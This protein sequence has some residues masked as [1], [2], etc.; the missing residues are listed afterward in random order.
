MAAF[1]THNFLPEIFQTDANKKFLNATVDQLISEPNFKRVNGYVGR[2]FAPT[3]KSSDSY[4]SEIDAQRQNYQLEPSVVIIDPQTNGINS[5]SSYTDLINKIKFY[6]GNV[7]NHS[8]MFE[9]EMYSYDGKFDFDKFVNFSQYCWLPNGPDSI[10]ISALG[11][12]LE[13]TWTVRVNSETKTY[14]FDDASKIAGN[15]NIVLARGGVYTFNLDNTTDPFWIQTKQGITGL[16]PSRPNISTRDVVGVTDNGATSGTVVFT[17]PQLSAQSRFTNMTEVAQVDYATSLSYH[18]IQG[19]SI[20]DINS[21]LGGLDGITG[22]LDGKK[23]VFIG[24]SVD[25]YHWTVP[26]NIDTNPDSPTYLT[27]IDPN[28]VVPSENRTKTWIINI[29]GGVVSLVANE[30]VGVNEK[31]YIKSGIANTTK[32][33][34]VDYHSRYVEFPLLTSSL[35]TLYYQNGNVGN[36]NGLITIVDAAALVIDPVNDIIGK[37]SYTSPT[38]VVF[39]N[40]MKIT[41]DSSAIG[42][43]ANNTYYVEGVGKSISLVLESNILPVEQWTKSSVLLAGTGYAVNDLLTVVGGT[44]DAATMIVDT[45]GSSGEILTFFVIDGGNYTTLP[46]NPVTVTGGTGTGAKFD[47]VLQPASKDY[48]TINRNSV[49]LNAW[50]RSNRWFH[51]DVIKATAVYNGTDFAIDQKNIAIR[52]IIEF[53]PNIKLFN[54]GEVARDPIDI[55]DTT[56]TNAYTQIENVS[57]ASSTTFI[58]TVNGTTVILHHG[59]RVVFS[60]DSVLSVRS[61]IYKFSIVNLSEN[62]FPNYVG[63]ITETGETISAGNSV[64]VKKGYYSGNEYYYDGAAWVKGQQKTGINQA[65]LFDMFDNSG[66]SFGDPAAYVNSSFVGTPIFSYKIGTGATDTELGFPLSYRTF[67]NVGDIQFSNSYDDDTFTYLVSPQTLTGKVNTGLLHV[68]KSLGQFDYSNIWSKVIEKSKQYQLISHTADGINNLFEIDILPNPTTTVPNIKVYVNNKFITVDNF[69]LSQIGVRYAVLVNPELLTAGDNVD[70]LIYSNSVSK[71]GFYQVPPSLDNNAENITFTSLTLGQIRNHLITL[72][73]NST[74][75]TGEV[76]GKNNLRDVYIKDHGGSIVKHSSAAVFSQLSLTDDTLNLIDSIGVAQKEYSKF[77]NKFL[78]LATQVHVENGADMSE[79]TDAILKQIN[80]IKNVTFPWYYSDMVPYGDNKTTLPSYTVLDPRIRSYELTTIFDDT[81]LSNKAVLVYLTR[82][83]N[84]TT[85]KKLL[86]KGKDY[87]FSKTNPSF[88]ISD[89]FNLNYGDILTVV[90]YSDTDGNYIPETPTKLGLYA[91]FVPV[92]YTDTT[93]ITPIDVI[94]GHDGSITPAFGDYRDDLLLELELRIYNNIKVTNQFETIYDYIPGKFRV[95]DYNLS[96]FNQ[97]L[98]NNFLTWVGNNRLD[99]TTNSYFDPADPWTYNYKNYK[100][101]INAEQLPGT[102]RAVF[103]WLFDTDRP[104]T[105]PWEMLGFSDEPDWWQDRYG[106]AP[107]TGGNYNLWSDLSIGYIHA[108]DRAGL[109]ARFARPNLLQII[110]VDESGNLRSPYEFAT[111]NFDISKASASFAIGNQGPVETAWRRSSNF[112]Y[113]MQIA[114]ALTKP[115]IY[116]GILAEVS[117]YQY[118]KNVGQYLNKTNNQHLQLSQ[119]VLNGRIDQTTGQITRSAGYTN[120]MSDFLTSTGVGYA[121]EVIAAYLDNLSVKLSYKVSGFTDKNYLKIL[122]EQGSPSSTNDSIVIPDE[123]YKV[124]LNKSTPVDRIVYSAVIVEKSTNGYTVS[125]YALN[126]PYF[127]IVPSIANNRAYSIQSGKLAGT[128]YQDYQKSLV[129]IPYGYEF[130]TSQQVVDFLVSYQRFLQSRGFTFAE[131][132]SDLGTKKDW[133]LSAKEFLTW[134]QQGWQTG[135]ILVLSPVNGTLNVSTVDSVVDSLSG[136]FN[137]TKLLDPNFAAIKPSSYTIVRNDNDFK[138]TTIKGQTICL[139]ELNLVQYEHVLVFDNKTVFNDIIYSPDTGNRQYRLKF[140]GYKTADWTGAMNPPGFVFNNETVDAWQSGKDYRKGQLVTYKNLYYTALSNVIASDTFMQPYWKQISKTQIKTGLLPNFALNAQTFEN[141]YDLDNPDPR[142]NI[143][144]YSSGITGFRERPY[145]T[146]LGID[147]DT[148]AKFYQGYIKQKGT[149]SAIDALAS[150][151]LANINSEIKV[152]EEWALRVGEY[153]ATDS[154]KF[155]EVELNESDITSNPVALQFLQKDETSASGAV[156]YTPTGLYKTSNATNLTFNEYSTSADKITLPVAGYVNVDD[157]DATIFDLS[158]YRNLTGILGSIGT[159]YTIWTAKDFSGQWN[160]FRVSETDNTVVSLTYNIDNVATFTTAKPHNFS[161]GDIVAVRNFD[162]TFDG[163]YQVYSVTGTQ[164]FSVVIANNYTAL[165]DAGTIYN[166]GI[167]FKLVSSRIAN[168]HLVDDITPT[169]GW[170]DNDK[171]WVDAI[172]SNGNWGVYNKTSPWDYQIKVQMNSSEYQ[173]NSG[174]GKSMQLSSDGKFMFVGASGSGRA[175][176]FVKVNKSW[177]ENSS[178]TD[179]VWVQ[180]SSFTTGATNSDQYGDSVDVNA[181]TFSVTAPGSNSN[182]GYVFLY[183]VDVAAG[184]TISQVLTA[185]SPTA[186]GKFGTAIDSSDDGAWLYIS[187]PGGDKVYVYNWKAQSSALQ[188]IPSGSSSVLLTQTVAA[189]SDILVNGN[190]PYIPGVDYHLS[191]NNIVFTTPTT[192]KLVVTYHG[193]Y[194]LYTTLTDPSSLTGIN[195]GY[196]LKTNPSGSQLVIGANNYDSGNGATYIFD[197]SIQRFVSTGTTNIFTPSTSLGTAYKV[198][199]NG[200]EIVDYTKYNNDIV[201][202]SVPAAGSIIDV[203]TNSFSFVQRMV[204]SPSSTTQRMGASVDICKNTCSIYASAPNYATYGYSSGAVYRFV[205]QGRVYGTMISSVKNPTVTLGHSI[206]INGTSVVFRSGTTVDSIVSAINSTNIAGVTATNYNGYVKIDSTSMVQLNKLDILPDTGTAF[207]NIGFIPFVQTQIITHP[208]LGESEYFGSSIKISDD[209]TSLVVSSLGASTTLSTMFDANSTMFDST[210]TEFKDNIAYSGAVYLYDLMENPYES[211]S[212]PSQMVYVQ[213]LMGPGLGSNFKFGSSLEFKNNFVYVG[214]MA[215]NALVDGGGS[216]YEFANSTTTGGWDLIRYET[217]K[218]D[219]LGLTKAFIYNKKTQAI[220]THL[221]VFDPAKGKI[222]GV[223]DQDL[224]YKSETDPAVYN[225]G[226]L[227]YSPTYHW[228]NQQVGRTWWDLSQVRFIDYE[229]DSLIY[230]N[231]HWGATF[232]DSKVIV[233]EWVESSVLPSQYVTNGGNG[234][235]KFADDSNYVSYTY[236]DQST[237]VIKNNYYFWVSGKTTVDTVL[238]NR[239]NSVYSIQQIIANPKDQGVSY[240]SVIAPNAVSLFN[241]NQYLS[242]KNVVLHLDQSYLGDTNIIHSEY[243]LLKEGSDR[244]EI[245]TRI[246]NKLQ[247]SLAGI[248]SAGLLVPDPQLL[249]SEKYGIGIRPRQTMFANVTSALENFVKYA[250]SVFMMNPMA[251]QFDLTRLNSGEP[252]PP[253]GT[254]VWDSSVAN[255]EELSYVTTSTLPDGYLLLVEVDTDHDGLWVIYKWTYGTSEWLVSRVQSYLTSLYYYTT[256]WYASDFDYT[257]SPTHTVAKFE[258]TKKLTLSIGDTIRVNDN[259]DSRFVYYRVNSSMTLDRVGS[260][261]GTIQLSDSLYDLANGNMGFDNDSFDTVRFDKTPSLETR[262]VFESVHKDLLIKDLRVEFNNLFFSLVN[263]IFSEQRAP[264][265][266]FKTSFISVMHRIR[267]LAQYPSYIKDNQTFYENY[268]NEVK[269]F[270]TSIREYIPSQSGTEYLHAGAADFDLP[271][272]Y[273]TTTNTYRQ[274]SG[275]FPS[276][277]ELLTTA[278]YADWNNN[279]LYKVTS[280]EIHNGGS[281]FT[282]IPSIEIIGGGGTGATAVATISTGS[283]SG[284]YITNPGSGYSTTPTILVNG[285]GTGAVLAPVLR[286]EYYNSAPADSYNT[287]RNISTTI[288][289]DRISYTSDVVE[290]QANTAYAATITSG[291]GNV[292]LSSGSLV[293][294]NGE[295][296]L[297]QNANTTSETTFDGSLYEKLDQ[298]NALISTNERIIGYYSPTSGMPGKDLTQLVDGIDYQGVQISG[299]SYINQLNNDTIISSAYV[300]GQLGTR[301]EDINVDGG[302]YVDEYSSHAPEELLPGRVYDTLEMKVF[303]ANTTSFDKNVY[304][305]GRIVMNNVGYGYSAADCHVGAVGIPNSYLTPVIAANGAIT[306]ITIVSSGISVA[307]NNI[308]PVI[309]ITGANASPASATGFLTQT[310]YDLIGYRIF[311]NMNGNVTYSRISDAYTTTLATP[312]A[313]TDS[314]IVVTNASVLPEPSVELGNPGV[315]F[316]NGEKITYY[317]IDKVANTLGQIRRAVDG[318]G[319][320]AVHAAG[321]RV[322]DSSSEQAMG[323]NVALK[324]WLNMTANVAD[325]TGLAGSTSTEAAFLKASLSYIP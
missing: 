295:I 254:G 107:Y 276:D 120:W 137:S 4:V 222:L 97:V 6:G 145:L 208:G 8:R 165:R 296:Y 197:R 158:N 291:I 44:G 264:D 54:Y 277:A 187:E 61:Q 3:F 133:I 204:S 68:I 314:N 210:S 80:G 28:L 283:I 234:I 196:S 216:I 49:D 114:L 108:G 100:D 144:F 66:F 207:A 141:I 27:P 159:G 69:G 94:Q 125:G 189:A 41:F 248:D 53:E 131:Y 309:S 205:N 203:E 146:D 281:G 286:N 16:D 124:F 153:G 240:I 85:T 253:A 292:W 89:K 214:A 52:P 191:G 304:R 160:V 315:V 217:P 1:K 280:I 235:P 229:Q 17:V 200:L 87:T 96:E 218:S 12:P 262:Y 250:N 132:D 162:T 32:Y 219:P 171:V 290:W 113:A 319:A 101:S 72:S 323:A 147:V 99:Y 129:K 307:T 318:T 242:D 38:G 59:D 238:T 172:D 98:T 82:T 268:I 51:V 9:N 186:S 188:E 260:Q 88:A 325:G 102:W 18:D 161:N 244:S 193:H 170:V 110:P 79:V 24:N 43:Y 261:N 35:T 60:N 252:I 306:S 135:N 255:R 285:N 157:V 143:N 40:G 226:F 48:L 305:V 93:Y 166:N 176:V 224:D 70:I 233:Y 258:D 312:L 282:F 180:N 91:K 115:G 150:A 259:G 164:T 202:A 267:E 303:T 25:D 78:E 21:I 181:H 31:V 75:I 270:R 42:G 243:E 321:S 231:K 249:A 46:T 76:P 192:E 178:F 308:N 112:P 121:R 271:S 236:V 57:A 169:Q 237:G 106:P 223:A 320:P 175:A 212:N 302:A 116:F 81:T 288:K 225:N 167:L 183:T 73:H 67:N 266:I 2:K 10:L 275:E 247:D 156:I 201:L 284:V 118:N 230:K 86:A 45:V 55:L 62:S 155:I 289:F 22:N 23:L 15:E 83:A 136:S 39:S 300:D 263:Y 245:P 140:V 109:D 152:Y 36:A 322:V 95:T 184:I 50:S 126:N 298:G 71:M 317:T 11:T 228:T 58:T 163:F 149:S 179:T 215:D 232:P 213:E 209:A 154:N 104:N 297:P 123:N 7:D 139:A 122:A 105:H 251:D 174:F 37:M 151:Q 119:V 278:D 47:L 310:A 241:V 274:P 311:Q 198:S 33:F 74:N 92:K 301:P 19:V 313:L 84:G 211:V 138:V 287:V 269:P 117:E 257:V 220:I 128:I 239:F 30:T 111:I 148:Q 272:Y 324:T 26:S 5:Y 64:L 142:E 103:K 182:Q 134:A 294:Y 130:T 256:D 279:H 63:I 190:H 14:Y 13:K 246:I 34:Y 273:D 20:A 195:F 227:N 56:I 168:P 177:I 194:S 90:E 29:V 293:S 173:T 265:W 185:P 221:D 199:L 77:K 65:P 127:T 299:N 316:I 206:R